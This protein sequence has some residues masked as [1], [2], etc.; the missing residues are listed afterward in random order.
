MM[1]NH[2]Y[3]VFTEK[4]LSP[5][6]YFHTLAKKLLRKQPGVGPAGKLKTKGT[7][8]LVWVMQ[9]EGTKQ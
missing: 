8:F 9:A 3:F 1:F 5:H 7:D 6:L 2:F 4:K